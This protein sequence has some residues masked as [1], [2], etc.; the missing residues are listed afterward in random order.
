MSMMATRRS[1]LQSAKC[2]N[3]SGLSS[4][5]V[6]HRFYNP[7]PEGTE[8][9]DKVMKRVSKSEYLG[10]KIKGVPREFLKWTDEW[11]DVFR[12]DPT[13]GRLHGDYQVMWRFNNKAAISEWMVSCDK[14]IDEGK[15]ECEFVLSPQ[16]TGVFR[17][18]VSTE[19]NKAGQAK[20]TG[21]CNIA[22][23][24]KTVGRNVQLTRC[25][26]VH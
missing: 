8:Y 1:V 10:N 16:G 3:S 6:R 17:G 25:V 5:F 19:L 2:F 7:T 12:M 20:R 13:C 21:Y 11:R 15:S 9:T 4:V 24:I 18:K 22:S 14:D 26:F 23:P